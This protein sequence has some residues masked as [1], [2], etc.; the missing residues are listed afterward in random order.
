M[1]AYRLVVKGRVQRV[2]FR[3]YVL[4]Q[5]RALGLKGNVRNEDDDS[6]HIH[7]QGDEDMLRRFI[8]LI[9]SA[10]PPAYV[11][12]VEIS[13]A[14]VVEDMRSFKII[15]GELGDELQEGFGAMQSVFD[16]Y[17]QEFRSYV[18]EFRSYVGEFRSY[19][20]EFREFARRT[21]QNFAEIKQELR[22]VRDDLKQEIQATRED[23][24]QEIRGVGDK[25]QAFADRTDKNFILLTTK[26]DTIAER[27][28]KILAALTANIEIL[29]RILERVSRQ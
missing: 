5:A 3:R 28:D 11:A 15:Y 21:D 16:D 19:V 8:E 7:A 2:G 13:P 26:Y 20:G 6:V 12:S 29:T 17:R 14:A 4:E 10:P 22:L 25:L 9:R 1:L 18:G 27:M 24:K 23:L